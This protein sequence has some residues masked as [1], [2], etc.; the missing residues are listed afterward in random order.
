MATKSHVVTLGYQIGSEATSKSYTKTAESE[1]NLSFNLPS[2]TTP[3]EVAFTLTAPG[4][5]LKAF[6]LVSDYQ[7]HLKTNDTASPGDEFGLPGG[8]PL[9]YTDDFVLPANG[10]FT[11]NVTKFYFYN[12][13]GTTAA[14][15]G[16]ALIDPIP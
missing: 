1:Q 4:G 15:V 10:P 9:V 13:S 12:T 6:Y 8:K 5:F 3:T 11:T 2:T 16:Y 7:A 14:V